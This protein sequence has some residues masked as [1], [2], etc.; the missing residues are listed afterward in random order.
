M[1]GRALVPQF[2]VW[3]VQRSGVK[4]RTDI[5]IETERT[6]FIVN[7]ERIV[8]WC[9][10]CRDEVKMATVDGAAA[11]AGISSLDIFRMIEEKRLHYIETPARSLL[12]CLNSLFGN[13]QESLST[14]GEQL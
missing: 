6:L 10:S 13:L 2:M 3:A 9:G 4:K 11:L 7:P 1:A 12:V 8:S 5:T 14:Q